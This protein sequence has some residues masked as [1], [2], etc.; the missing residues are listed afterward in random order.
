MCPVPFHLH[1]L[2][3][4][5][6]RYGWLLHT[7]VEASFDLFRYLLLGNQLITWEL[8]PLVSYTGNSNRATVLLQMRTTLSS[9]RTMAS[10]TTC[11]NRR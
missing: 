10:G 9:T 2:H 7:L 6:V 4:I 1:W 3:G 8:H 5:T 11:G